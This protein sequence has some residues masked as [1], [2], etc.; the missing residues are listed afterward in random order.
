MRALFYKQFKLVCH[1]MTLL[2]TVFG[3]MFLIPN[4]PYTVAFFYVT[5]GLFFMMQNGRE[6]RD[7]DFSA[8]LPIRKRDTVKVTVLFSVMVELFSLLV[9]VPFAVL[10]AQMNPFGGN[11]AGV[12]ANMAAFGIAFLLFAVFNYTFYVNFYRTGYKVGTAFIKAGIAMF[13]V[14]LCDVIL[15]HV[16][17]LAWLDGGEVGKQLPFLLVCG[18]IYGVSTVLTYRTAAKRYEKVDL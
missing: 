8:L 6:Q 9:A 1:P 4:Y 3:V 18:A 13:F 7:T 12:D 15:P 17:G 14:V 10:S 16:P 5:L 2:F 11:A